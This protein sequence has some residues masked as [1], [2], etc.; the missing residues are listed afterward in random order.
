MTEWASR[1][2]VVN[3]GNV[4]FSISVHEHK[5]ASGGASLITLTKIEMN[6]LNSYIVKIRP[7]L[8]ADNS[9]YV[10]PNLR[11]P[12]EPIKEIR[13]TWFNSLCNNLGQS[14]LRPSYILYLV[15][16]LPRF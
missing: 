9:G 15:M 12:T 14:V 3:D 1:R 4:S 10:F 11:R 16:S 13:F 2:K 7:K 6:V 5:T 8:T